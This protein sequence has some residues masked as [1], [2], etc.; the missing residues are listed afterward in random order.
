MSTE[1]PSRADGVDVHEVEDGLVVYQAATDRV[2]YLNPSAS[3]I[4]E[5][6][7]GERTGDQI[8]ELVRAAWGLRA[9][10]HNEVTECLERF[11]AEGVVR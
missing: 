7:N 9:P 8:A 5:F 4:F 11:R 2:H 1:C 10:P 6:C 3:I